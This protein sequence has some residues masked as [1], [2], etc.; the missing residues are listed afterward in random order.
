MLDEQD[1]LL[2]ALLGV[3]DLALAQER[4][5]LPRCSLHRAAKRN[6]LSPGGIWKVSKMVL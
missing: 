5:I 1:W 2:Q 6:N 4:L 3:L